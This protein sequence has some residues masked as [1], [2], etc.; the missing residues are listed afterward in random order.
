MSVS[1]FFCLELGILA[2]FRQE[3]LA[4]VSLSPHMIFIGAAINCG[5]DTV[6]VGAEIIVLSYLTGLLP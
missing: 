6:I 5:K 1:V 3:C 2:L 4:S